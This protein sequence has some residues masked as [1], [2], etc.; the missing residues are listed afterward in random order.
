[1]APATDYLWINGIYDFMMAGETLDIFKKDIKTYKH[2]G[3]YPH[4]EEP[5]T[6]VKDIE[7]FVGVAR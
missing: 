1:M 2:S 5:Y 3:H 7:S 6:L 4:I